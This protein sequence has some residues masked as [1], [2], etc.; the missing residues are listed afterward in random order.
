MIMAMI[1]TLFLLNFLQT[2]YSFCPEGT[3]SFV[4]ADLAVA[5]LNY[6]WIVNIIISH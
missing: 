1:F 4:F 3:L 2:C 6:V 5:G